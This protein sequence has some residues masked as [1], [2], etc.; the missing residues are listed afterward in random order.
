M[1]QITKEYIDKEKSKVF[2][3]KEY[4]SLTDKKKI[5]ICKMVIEWI[6]DEINIIK[7]RIN[8]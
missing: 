3:T 7:N 5:E 4:K 1:N 6:T 8:E 2:N